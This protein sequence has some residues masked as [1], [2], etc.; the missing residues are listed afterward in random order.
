MNS[1]RR[2]RSRKRPKAKG[3]AAVGIACALVAGCG[4][5]PEPAPIAPVPSDWQLAWHELGFYG[6]IH[7]GP[8]TFL[9]Q[10]WGYG[11][12]DPAVFNPTELDCDQWARVAQSAGMKGLILTA[13]HHDGFCLWPSA[14]TEYSVKA[15]PWKNGQGDV[16]AEL[17]A[18]CRKHGLKLG[19]YLSPWDRH[20]PG[21]GKP[22]YIDY[23]RAQLRELL[24][25]YGEVFEVWFDG[26]NG[27]NGYYGGARENRTIDRKSY[28]DWP[29]TWALVREHQPHAVMF[30]DAGP[31]VRWVG[32][33][34]GWAN[35]TNWCP[36][37]ADEAWP[38][39]P[40][41]TENR[42]GH[43]QGTHWVPAEAD[44]SIRPGWFY[45]A[46]QDDEVKT[47]PQLLDIYDKSVGRNANLLLNLPVDRRGLIPETDAARLAGLGRAI[48]DRFQ[49]DLALGR[50]VQASNVRGGN[51][52]FAPSHVTD[53]DPDTF[54]STDDG[55]V[56]ATL[57]VQ[58][59]GPTAVNGILL[60]EAV[61]LG[62]RVKAFTV[63]AESDGVWTTVAQGSTIGFRRILWF[64]TVPATRIRVHVTDAKGSPCLFALKLYRREEIR[65]KVG[66][67]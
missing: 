13:K 38:G 50:P 6:F 1:G 55:V 34:E 3:W 57:T 10:E 4:R 24:T 59:D 35:V 46:S 66:I 64:P 56:G 11:D 58:M 45:H 65:E 28:Y 8:N 23:Y 63:E 52:R 54:W 19:L 2:P 7:F 14:H 67:E 21:Y 40:R 12:A 51:K 17:A 48:R 5:T 16:V 15:S 25:Q 62:Q 36:F 39:W 22:T 27:G 33:E 9:D 49:T 60:Q 29:T 31:D 18:A 43:E 53:G 44:V 37:L 32:N 30:S 42:S 26:A 41:Y 20:H 61:R 47:V